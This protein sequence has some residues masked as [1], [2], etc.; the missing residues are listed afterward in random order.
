MT[1]QRPRRRRAL[2]TVEDS[3]LLRVFT[4]ADH[5]VT[6]PDG[7]LYISGGGVD[8]MFL[9]KIP[10]QLGPL[11]VAIRVRVPWS[12]TSEQLA[13]QIRILDADRQPVGR[14]PVAEGVIEVGRAPGQRA[15]DELGVNAAIPLTG[16]AVE[17]RATLYVHVVVD[18]DTLGVLPLKVAPLPRISE[19]S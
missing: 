4:L 8:Q 13:L 11:Y 9:P 7:K 17:K 6:P 3:V 2:D 12:R 1:Q 19:E 16:F 18:G 15:G 5:A 14:D 10:G